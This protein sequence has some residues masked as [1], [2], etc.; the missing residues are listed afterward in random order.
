MSQASQPH[1]RPD[2]REASCERCN[3]TFTPADPADPVHF[4]DRDGELCGGVGRY[5][6]PFVIRKPNRW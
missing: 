4:Q 1:E 5:F 2:L 6:R 3:Q